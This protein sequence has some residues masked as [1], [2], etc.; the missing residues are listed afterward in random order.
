MTKANDDTMTEEQM[1][2]LAPPFLLRV[3]AVLIDYIVFLVLPLGSLVSE[4]MLGGAGLGLMSDRT[5]W[6][7]ACVIGFVNCV[8]FPQIGGQSVGKLMTGIRIVS[9]GTGEL[10]RF[11]LFLRQTV[12]YLV[13]LG[14]LGLGFL[15]AAILPSGRTLHDAIFATTTV[16]ARKTLVR[17]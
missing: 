9:S 5:V 2:E 16:R 15:V 13:T 4:R 3:G 6:L 1:T 10:G 7:F 14:T 8:V 17:V 12:G 11:R